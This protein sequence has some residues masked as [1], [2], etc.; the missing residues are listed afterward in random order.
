MQLT[1]CGIMYGLF[2]SDHRADNGCTRAFCVSIVST[3]F[4]TE[5]EMAVDHCPKCKGAME[6]GY[7][8]DHT[9][10]ARVVSHW[11]KGAPQKSFFMG[12]KLPDQQLVPIGT[13]R[14]S[15]CG[16]LEAYARPEFAAK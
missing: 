1:K 15:A 5:N 9:Y 3:V 11:A 8:L 2:D 10:G 13:Y 4:H 6:Q 14:C 7:V 16:Y 12:T